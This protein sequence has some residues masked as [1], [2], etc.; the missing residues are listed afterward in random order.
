MATP[1]EIRELQLKMLQE[2]DALLTAVRPMSVEVA[3]HRPPDKDGEDGWSVK[4][5]LV[6][7]AQMDARYRSWCE[8]TVREE[9]PDLDVD[10][11]PPADPARYG[12]DVA[13]DVSVADLITEVDRQRALTVEFIQGLAPQDFDRVSSNAMFGELTVLQWLRSCYR[14]DRMHLAQV[15]HRASEYQPRFLKGEPDQR[16]RPS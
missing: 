10:A 4:E 3:E 1:D 6:H 12:M 16:R 15:E 13:H 7:L 14:H 9:R 11:Q 2:R 8:R 5:Q